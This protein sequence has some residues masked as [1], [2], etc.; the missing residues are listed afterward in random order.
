[1]NN[2]SRV[3]VCLSGKK[4]CCD[5][6]EAGNALAKRDGLKLS[7]LIALPQNA[8]FSPD[9][10]TLNM[11]YEQ[12]KK[13]DAELT[14]FFNDAPAECA[15]EFARKSHAFSIVTGFPSDKSSHFVSKIHSMLPDVP[16]NMVRGNKVFH[17]SD[18]QLSESESQMNQLVHSKI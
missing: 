12:S 10:D 5:L 6:I 18:A 3:L 14:V 15:A 13:F 7:I 4:D 17:L 16:I 2:S 9:R 11:L 8:C 1:M